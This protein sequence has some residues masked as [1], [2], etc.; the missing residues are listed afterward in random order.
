MNGRV[1]P[2]EFSPLTHPHRNRMFAITV[3][4]RVIFNTIS[5]DVVI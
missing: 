1:F 2:T 3:Y 4:R 5:Y